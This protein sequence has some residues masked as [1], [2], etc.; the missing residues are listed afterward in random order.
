M[1]MRNRLLAQVEILH[2]WHN[3]RM[4]CI[5]AMLIRYRQKQPAH[6][7]VGRVLCVLTPSGPLLT[8]PKSSRFPFLRERRQYV[9]QR[10]C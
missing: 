8:L 5:T 4:T 10:G 3:Y 2:R 1:L 6:L 7:H 9:L